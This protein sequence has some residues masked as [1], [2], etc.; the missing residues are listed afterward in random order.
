MTIKPYAVFY[1]VTV[2]LGMLLIL[3]TL[4]ASF[5]PIGTPLIE[6]LVVRTCLNTYAWVVAMMVTPLKS[7]GG[8]LVKRYGRATATADRSSSSSSSDDDDDE[9]SSS[10]SEDD[11]D[12]GEADDDDDDEGNSDD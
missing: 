6:A 8:I 11:D 4:N 3:G 12:D 7:T 10:G 1:G 5:Y 2:L 9:S